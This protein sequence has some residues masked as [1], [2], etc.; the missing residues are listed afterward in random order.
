M[1]L[2]IPGCHHPGAISSDPP[3]IPYMKAD[4][5][6]D[7]GTWTIEIQTF[8]NRAQ[9]NRWL[10]DA[11]NNPDGSAPWDLSGPYWI[12]SIDSAGSS[13]R[14]TEPEIQVVQH[15]LGGKQIN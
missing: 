11:V 8:S 14:P 13:L 15:H 1:L 10:S 12:A 4:E 3:A 5:T 7:T 2:S 6:C 9:I